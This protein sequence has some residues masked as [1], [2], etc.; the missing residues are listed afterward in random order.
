MSRPVSL[1]AVEA[2]SLICG[3]IVAAIGVRPGP[4]PVGGVPAD[5]PSRRDGHR[6]AD[7]TVAF[8][9]IVADRLHGFSLLLISGRVA[10]LPCGG[11]SGNATRMFVS[12]TMT[13]TIRLPSS[14]TSR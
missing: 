8:E 9:L 1:E 2:M 6:R 11:I 5:D 14:V 7:S 4:W 3:V 10:A 12:T 13:A